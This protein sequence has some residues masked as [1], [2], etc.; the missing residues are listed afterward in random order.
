MTYTDAPWWQT[1][2][3]LAFAMGL[4]VLCLAGARE[5]LRPGRTLVPAGVGGLVGIGTAAG[6]SARAALVVAV[7]TFGWWAL[8]HAADAACRRT[9]ADAR[10]RL[11]AGALVLISG[12]GWTLGL[13]G[14]AW[15][16]E[17]ESRPAVRPA[18]SESPTPLQAVPG[19][20]PG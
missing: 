3:Q 7:V 9:A 2:A 4:G 12:L 18:D 13:A 1:Y 16:S 20:G 5:L 8:L 6:V 11:L 10:G 17:A 19:D 14:A 15:R